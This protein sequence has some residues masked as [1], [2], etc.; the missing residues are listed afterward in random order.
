MLHPSKVYRAV[1]RVDDLPLWIVRN[2]WQS[3][4]CVRMTREDIAEELRPVVREAVLES[5]LRKVAREIGVSHATID[6]FVSGKVPSERTL[7][8]TRRWAA[9]KGFVSPGDAESLSEAEDMFSSFDALARFVGG[10][11]PPGEEKLVK[12][13]ALEGYR[14]MITARG[15]LPKWWYRLKEM[16]ERDEL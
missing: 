8:L 12:L 5:S 15:P 2:V 9:R 14:R 7:E 3:V 1:A 10:I 4:K 16:V 11:A 6:D 13:D